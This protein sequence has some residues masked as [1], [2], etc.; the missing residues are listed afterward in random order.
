MQDTSFDEN[1]VTLFAWILLTIPRGTAHPPASDQFEMHIPRRDVED[2]ET[3]KGKVLLE[4]LALDSS[5]RGRAFS[6]IQD[7]ANSYLYSLPL[8]ESWCEV[9]T[10]SSPDPI[11]KGVHLPMDLVE[12]LDELPCGTQRFTASVTLEADLSEALQGSSLPHAA[13]LSMYGTES[14]LTH[15]QL[16][17][18]EKRE[19]HDKIATSQWA[20]S[21]ETQF[22]LPRTDFYLYDQSGRHIGT[23]FGSLTACLRG[24]LDRGVSEVASVGEGTSGL[25]KL[26]TTHRTVLDVSKRSD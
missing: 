12:W 2:E 7:P 23:E 19:S 13:V 3:W 26:K 15:V 16:I 10:D 14:P 4:S 25:V 6:H 24:R 21:F 11:F 22:S 18:L 1:E 9:A 8:C 17:D 5:C 20:A